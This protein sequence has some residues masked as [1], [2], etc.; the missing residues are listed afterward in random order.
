MIEIE[1]FSVRLAPPLTTARGTITEREGFLVTVEYDETLGVGEATPLTGWTESLD[2]CRDALE[3]ARTVADEL[4]WGIALTKMETPAARHGLSLAFAEA[5]ARAAN[6]PLY[7]QL[8]DGRIVERVPV[9]TTLD[10]AQDPDE[11][12]AAASEA[13]ESGYR[14]LKLKVG[15]NGLEDDIERVRAVRNAVGDDIELRVDANGAWTESQAIEAIDALAAL[16]VSYI[17]QPLPAGDLD[18]HAN[19]RG[20]P[21]DIAVDE[22]LAVHDV[23]TILD[24]DAADVLVLKPM[25]L[26]GPDRAR[27]AAIEARD[28]DVEPVL[29]TTLDAVVARTGA[30]HVAASIPDIRPCGLATAGRL[31]TDLAPD[32]APVEDGWIRV[33]QDKGLGLRDRPAR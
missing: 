9:N 15:T 7:R 18:G 16:D 6:H 2:E 13:V 21:V 1:P 26:G 28:A 22:S 32:P 25:V 14:S 4:D 33:P 10:A 11:V 20:G 23:E 27:A 5:R 3:Q 19:L 17:E 12:V 24:S 29:S 8:G 30:V 31:A